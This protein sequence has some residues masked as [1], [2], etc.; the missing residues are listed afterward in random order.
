MN[1]NVNEHV[2]HDLSLI[3]CYQLMLLFVRFYSRRILWTSLWDGF[4]CLS[5][6]HRG[7][8]TGVYLN[9]VQSEWNIWFIL[10]LSGWR[11]DL[12][13]P[14]SCGWCPLT[15]PPARHLQRSVPSNR[16]LQKCCKCVKLQA[17]VSSVV[18]LL[19]DNSLQE[20]LGGWMQIPLPSS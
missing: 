11:S 9:T 1:K 12:S 13:S 19:E 14:V 8:L 16:E 3:S 4:Q 15:S 17:T 7:T 20:Q 5:Q 10:S 6:G 2:T 18:S